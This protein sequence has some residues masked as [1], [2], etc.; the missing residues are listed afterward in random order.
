MHNFDIRNMEYHNI[1]RA[2]KIVYIYVKGVVEFDVTFLTTLS[3]CLWQIL[4]RI[5]SMGSNFLHSMLKHQCIFIM[6]TLQ[7]FVQTKLMSQRATTLD[8]V[9]HCYDEFVAIQTL[10]TR[11]LGM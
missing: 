3:L 8:G 11:P 10:C 7:I 4:E 6:V 2:A 5:M 1:Y 9:I